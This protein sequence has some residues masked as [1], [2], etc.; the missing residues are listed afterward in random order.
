MGLQVPLT[1]WDL[2]NA[3]NRACALKEKALSPRIL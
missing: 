3:V 1:W 2:G